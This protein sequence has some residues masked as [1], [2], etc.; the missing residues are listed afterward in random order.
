MEKMARI[1]DISRNDTKDVFIKLNN[2]MKSSILDREDVDVLFVNYNKILENPKDS[3]H[4]IH[5]F[6]NSPEFSL[7]QMINCVD[8]KLYRKRRIK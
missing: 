1:E 8:Q 5:D 6:F 7:K 2:R 3:I 4:K